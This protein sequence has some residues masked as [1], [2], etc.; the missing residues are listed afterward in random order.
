MGR[1]IY[2]IPITMEHDNNISILRPD[3][4]QRSSNFSANKFYSPGTT[5]KAEYLN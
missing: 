4:Q 1:D 2:F 5:V 3:N